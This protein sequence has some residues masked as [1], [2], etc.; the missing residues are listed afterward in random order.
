MT[1]EQELKKLNIL[2]DITKLYRGNMR[3]C[4]DCPKTTY[5]KPLGNSYRGSDGKYHYFDAVEESNE[6]EVAELVKGIVQILRKYELDPEK[7]CHAVRENE[8]GQSSFRFDEERGSFGGC[9]SIEEFVDAI[10]ELL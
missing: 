5:I 8:N 9:I 6:V 1:T 10:Q 7:V 4:L 3:Q 2:V